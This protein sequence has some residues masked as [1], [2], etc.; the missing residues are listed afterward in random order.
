MVNQAKMFAVDDLSE[1]LKSAKS[2]ALIDYQGLTAEQ[3]AELRKKVKEA[4]GVIE[5]IKNTLIQRGLA[6]IGILPSQPLIGPTAVVFANDDEVEP[7]K[8]IQQ[9]AKV[10]Q[11]PEFKF[12]VYNG[13]I[14]PLEKLQ[15]FVDLPGK[16]TLLAQFVGGLANPLSRL[17]YGLNFNQTKLVLALKEI[18]KS[19]EAN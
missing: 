16:E 19:K 11:K 17:V 6:K 14:L 10:F 12:G 3:L 15:R 9:A 2:A 8:I 1:K 13:E 5:V 7:L 18:G 4:S